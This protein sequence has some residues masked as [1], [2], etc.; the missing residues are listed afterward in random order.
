LPSPRSPTFSQ[1]AQVVSPST[2]EQGQ[3]FFDLQN[4]ANLHKQEASYTPITGF[5]GASGGRKNNVGVFLA[6]RG[7]GDNESR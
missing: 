3:G 6:Q 1:E 5:T 7:G 4:E 2:V